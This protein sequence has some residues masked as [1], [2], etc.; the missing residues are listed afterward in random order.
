MI[1][2]RIHPKISEEERSKFGKVLDKGQNYRLSDI[3]GGILDRMKDNLGQE[4]VFYPSR[5]KLEQLPLIS[6]QNEFSS[7]DYFSICPSLKFGFPIQHK[8]YIC[9]MSNNRAIN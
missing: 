4:C 3:F 7:F 6:K 1:K 8:N 9:E 2:F 5:A